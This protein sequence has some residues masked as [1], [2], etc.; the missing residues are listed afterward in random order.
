[1]M[2][3]P[4]RAAPPVNSSLQSLNP[5]AEPLDDITDMPHL[6]ELDLELVDLAQDLAKAG[7]FGVG[8]GDGGGGA[9]GL[10]RGGAL[11]LG[12]ELRGVGSLAIIYV[13]D[14]VDAR[15]SRMRAWRVGNQIPMDPCLAPHFMIAN[16]EIDQKHT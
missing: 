5:G 4:P 15:N 9:G 14:G 11:G 8:D 2:R 6:V 3:S 12:C 1:M 7:D 10:V 16:E 13:C